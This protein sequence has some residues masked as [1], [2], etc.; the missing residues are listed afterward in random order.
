MRL[1]LHDELPFH[2]ERR[3]AKR[4]YPSSSKCSA[5]LSESALSASCGTSAEVSAARHVTPPLLSHHERH[6]DPPIGIPRADSKGGHWVGASYE[7]S[8]APFGERRWLFKDSMNPSAQ[9][10][11]FARVAAK[12]E[13]CIKTKDD[14]LFILDVR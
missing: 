8:T 9:I 12:L 1:K 13:S 11:P 3:L 4:S 5:S 2:S 7:H 6:V 10:W 14:Y